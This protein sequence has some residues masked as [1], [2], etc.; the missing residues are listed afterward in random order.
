LPHDHDTPAD[1]H[2]FLGFATFLL[3]LL[4]A[5]ATIFTALVAI[6]FQDCR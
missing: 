5:L 1:R 4:S 6:F 3:G 2:R